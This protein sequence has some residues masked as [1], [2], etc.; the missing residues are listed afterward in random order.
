MIG[1][2]SGARKDEREDIEQKSK[3]KRVLFLSRFSDHVVVSQYTDPISVHRKERTRIDDQKIQIKDI[4][5]AA[6]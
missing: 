5:I 4:T 3:S 2:E 1:V 6:T